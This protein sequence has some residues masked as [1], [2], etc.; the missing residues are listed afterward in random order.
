MND[1]AALLL[2]HDPGKQIGVIEKAWVEDRKLRAVIRFSKSQLGEEIYQDVRDGIRTKVSIGYRVHDIVL[3]KQEDELNTYRVTDWEPYE[4]S[5]VAIPADASVGVGRASLSTPLEER[6]EERLGYREELSEKSEEPPAETEIKIKQEKINNKE[7]KKMTNEMRVSEI[8]A[9]AERHALNL[10]WAVQDETVTIEQVRGFVLNSLPASKP[11]YQ[12][13]AEEIGMSKKEIKDY[14]LFRLFDSIKTGKPCFEREV[15]D[16]LARR[17]G[18]APRGLY[19]AYDAIMKRD[20]SAGGTLTGAEMVGTDHR[21]DLF[22]DLL[23][24][25]MLSTQLGVRMLTG[26]KGNIAIPKL[27]TGSTYAWI[28]TENGVSAESTPATAQV[29]LSP[30]RGGTFVD[31][32]KQLIIQ[33]DPSAEALVMND[34]VTICALGLDA[35]VFHGTGASGQPYGIAATSG[36]GTFTGASFTWATA[37][38]AISDVETAN[39]DVNTM[40]FVSTPGHR[41]TLKSREISSGHPTFITGIDNTMAGYPFLASNQITTNYVFFGDFSQVMVGYWGGIDLTLDPYT[42]AT[43]G[44]ER[45]VVQQLVDVAV[46]Q[47]G[48]LTFCTDFS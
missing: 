36:V 14:S 35:A 46:R 40:Y 6:L 42:L 41:A 8:K 32:S 13:P 9:L 2:N 45:I 21:G 38:D 4:G 48:A 47:T 29:T 43:Y 22:I 16:E 10:D 33:S 34:L 7:K 25:R 26:L 39:A 44:L 31:V 37:F 23:R 15:S 19:L 24:N 1:K 28:S 17:S 3:E 11:L 27:T 20:L 18:Q 5:I 12:S 30:H